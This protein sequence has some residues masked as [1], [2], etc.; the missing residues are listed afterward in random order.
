MEINKQDIEKEREIIKELQRQLAKKDKEIK[1]YNNYFKSFGC[2]DF[3]EFQELI[4]L[5]KISANDKARDAIIRHQVCDEIRNA[6]NC[7]TSFECDFGCDVVFKK[8]FDEYLDEI[9]KGEE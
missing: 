2:K 1:E 9:E 6:V 4:G 7:L 8:R 3:A 5:T